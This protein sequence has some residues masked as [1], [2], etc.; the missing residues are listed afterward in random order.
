MPGGDCVGTVACRYE[1][2]NSTIFILES[3]EPTALIKDFQA[4]CGSEVSVKYVH[5]GENLDGF[6]T[7]EVETPFSVAEIF[8]ILPSAL[9]AFRSPTQVTTVWDGLVVVLQPLLPAEV[10]K[11]LGGS[12]PGAAVVSAE[13]SS[14]DTTACV[15]IPNVDMIAAR[16]DSVFLLTFLSTADGESCIGFFGWRFHA[17]QHD[18]E[19]RT[20]IW[21]R[22]NQGECLHTIMGLPC[23]GS[24]QRHT[25]WNV[26]V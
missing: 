4:F 2:V 9:F 6:L 24:F 23:C 8:E 20:R 13:A 17:L 14:T 11:V 7:E 16:R 19:R 3:T 22:K 1:S 10:G 26:M 5:G 21:N 15:T 25:S 12:W 18:V